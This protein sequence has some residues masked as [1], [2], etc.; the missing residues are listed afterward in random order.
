VRREV[1]R[2]ADVVVH[3]AALHAPHVGRRPDAEFWA[4][5]VDATRDLLAD[6]AAGGVSRFVF[7]SSTSVYG[8]AL[9]PAGG[10]AVWVDETLP[11]RPRDV[12][13]ETKLAA[14]HLVAASPVPAVTLR[15]SRCFPEPPRELVIHR[16][17]RGVDLADVAAAVRLAVGRDDVRGTFTISGPH[18]FTPADRLRLH[19]DAAALIAERVPLV[20]EAFAARGWALPASIDRVYDSTAAAEAFGYRP[21]I[22]APE[23][24]AGLPE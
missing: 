16:L 7:V 6:A 9:V 10:R 14:E 13:D 23:V 2:G 1:L 12:Y 11:A 8:H 24:A 15:I 21:R 19:D 17:H 22:G 3:A 18:P 4:V 20:A 5:N